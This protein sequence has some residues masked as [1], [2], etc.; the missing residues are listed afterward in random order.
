MTYETYKI[1]HLVGLIVLYLALGAVLLSPENN[2]EKPP[3]VAA[4]LHGIGLLV[5]LVAGFGML[6]RLNVAWPWPT[7]VFLKLGI[8]ILLGAMPVLVRKGIIPRSLGWLF[9]G[10]LGGAAAWLAITKLM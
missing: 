3:K 5:M 9:A 2:G 4:A 7:W 1:M 8:W 6:D 10:A